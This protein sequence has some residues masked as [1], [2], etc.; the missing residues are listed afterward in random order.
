MNVPFNPSSPPHQASARF[1]IA[2]SFKRAAAYGGSSVAIASAL[3]YLTIRRADEALLGFYGLTPFGFQNPVSDLIIFNLPALFSL[4]LFAAITIALFQAFLKVSAL[5]LSW[6]SRFRAFA[7][8]RHAIEKPF[9]SAGWY[10][11]VTTFWTL[12]ALLGFL[13]VF[14]FSQSGTV[15]GSWRMSRAEWIVS[16][17]RCATDCY[18][19]SV[20]GSTSPVVGYP[21]AGNDARLAIVVSRRKVQIVAMD[22]MLSV[23][24]HKGKPVPGLEEA[25]AKLRW[26]WKMLDLFNGRWSASN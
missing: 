1:G 2:K 3:L 7:L 14:V 17:N 9:V 11:N 21:V 23:A 13:T 24:A 5:F 4:S 18:S 8:V 20:E 19:Y 16:G 26:Q 15:L 12:V 6:A 10:R 25:P 22:K